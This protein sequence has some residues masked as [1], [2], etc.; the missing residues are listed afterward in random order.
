MVGARPCPDCG[1][2]LHVDDGFMPWCDCGWNLVAAEPP[3]RGRLERASLAVAGRFD[4]RVGEIVTVSSLAPRLTIAKLS[5]YGIS[6]LVYLA[7]LGLFVGGVV[8]A[9]TTR[10][11]LGI[12]F[13]L[14]SA[15]LGFVM[16]P[17]LG[18]AP[19]EHILDRTTAPTFHGLIEEIAESLETRSPDVVVVIDDYNAWWGV[20]GLRRKRVLAIGSALFVA[21]AP[22]ERVAL[23]AHE[24][25]H[26]RN[27]DSSRSVIVGGAMNALRE[28]YRALLGGAGTLG[29]SLPIVEWVARGL[30]WLVARPILG[31]Y[32][33]L[34]L[35][36]LRD[37]H[38]A[39][40]L[41]DALAARVAGSEAEIGVEEKLLLRS[42]YETVAIRTSR[43]EGSDLFQQLR[44][45][46]DGVPQRERERRRR[47]ARLERLQLTTTHPPT[48]RRIELI[49]ARPREPG[50]VFLDEERSAKIDRELAPAWLASGAR[51]ADDS[52]AAMYY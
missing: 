48:A 34:R 52:R 36:L 38:R 31:L 20:F 42:V 35:L 43:E 14:G 6:L 33:V 18:K 16:R 40:Y 25:A 9:V 28:V 37:S 8:L 51:I 11:L 12:V 17:R 5:A 27:G 47:T 46:I 39:E 32:Y 2:L 50:R 4:R 23:I 30:L 22:G 24:L 41:A 26:A 49:E 19:E 7:A 15:L 13:G 44:Q 10:S 1:D 3:G 21:L 29:D 45:A